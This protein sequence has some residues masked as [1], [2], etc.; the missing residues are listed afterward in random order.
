[1]RTRVF[2]FLA[3]MLIAAAGL[4]ADSDIQSK[5]L[6]FVDQGN[7]TGS[8]QTSIVTYRDKNGVEVSLVSAIHIGDK[9]A[10]IS[11][12]PARSLKYLFAQQMEGME[13]LMAGFEEDGESVIVG[14]RNK[15]AIEVPKKEMKLG[16]KKLGIFYGAAH[17]PDMEKRLVKELHFIQVGKGRWLIAWDIRKS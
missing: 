6:Q 15:V 4:P 3:A 16:R 8:L 10:F 7:E 12:D 14:E 9:K 17:M 2:Y 11:E 13:Y 5:F 1:M